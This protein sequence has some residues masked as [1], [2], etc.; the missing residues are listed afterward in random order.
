MLEWQFL[1]FCWFT[2]VSFCVH[3]CY[4]K[5]ATHL[6]YPHEWPQLSQDCQILLAKLSRSLIHVIL[7]IPSFV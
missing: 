4:G 1:D 5:L 6:D 2:K 7:K 3:A